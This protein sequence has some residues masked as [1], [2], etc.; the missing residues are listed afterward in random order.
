MSPF[1]E[2]FSFLRI[3]HLFLC[4]L[5]RRRRVVVIVIAVHVF[6]VFSL[7]KR[8]SQEETKNP[9][10]RLFFQFREKKEQPTSSLI[11]EG[12]SHNLYSHH[13]PFLFLK[14]KRSILPTRTARVF[15][16]KEGS[17]LLPPRRS[18]FVKRAS[19]F[20]TSFLFSSSILS[21]VGI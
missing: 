11:R 20:E 4:I 15:R 6:N 1:F 19:G 12:F 7:W 21:P 16:R 13:I 17:F 18:L 8:K 5:S 10:K 3:L 14:K 2:R 9:T